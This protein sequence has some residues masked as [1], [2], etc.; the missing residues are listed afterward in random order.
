MQRNTVSFRHVL[1]RQMHQA[2]PYTTGEKWLAAGIFVAIGILFLSVFVALANDSLLWLTITVWIVVTAPTAGL[3]A[4]LFWRFRVITNVVK[5]ELAAGIPAPVQ[6][7]KDT[8]LFVFCGVLG[9][10]VA[11]VTVVI[12]LLLPS[13]EVGWLMPITLLLIVLGALSTALWSRLRRRGA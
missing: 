10:V 7:E 3:V 4:S 2:V 8:F 1:L 5:A 6:T 12:W 13:R 11:P 9:L